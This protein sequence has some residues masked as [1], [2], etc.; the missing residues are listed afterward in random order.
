M[1]VSSS[2]YNEIPDTEWLL[3]N[4]LFLTVLESGKHQVKA[5][6]DSV[7][8]ETATVFTGIS[9]ETEGTGAS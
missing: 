5:L 9:H 4:D 7:C 2:C 8:G 6:A 3:S 1:L